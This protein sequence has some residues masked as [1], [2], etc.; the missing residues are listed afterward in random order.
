MSYERAAYDAGYA[1]RT[2]ELNAAQDL[3]GIS[4]VNF[5]A[6]AHIERMRT[7]SVKDI[8]KGF[9]SLKREASSVGRVNGF[10]MDHAFNKGKSDAEK[11]H[12]NAASGIWM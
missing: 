6:R 10:T 9:R 11:D 12:K 2:C 1:L 4:L 5:S 7:E 8:L 3:A